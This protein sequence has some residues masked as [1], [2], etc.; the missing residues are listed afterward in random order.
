[1]NKSLEG[2]L[3]LQISKAEFHKKSSSFKIYFEF[4]LGNK[5]KK[6][7]PISSQSPNWKEKITLNYS[8][9]M[10]FFF[11]VLEKKTLRKDPVLFES[12]VDLNQLRSK[13]KMEQFITVMSKTKLKGTLTLIFILYPYV[14][15]PMNIYPKIIEENL[16]QSLGDEKIFS[17][18]L[19]ND[20]RSYQMVLNSFNNS[21]LLQTYTKKLTILSTL[22]VPGCCKFIEITEKKSETALY[23]LFIL[24]PI[25]NSKPLAEDILRRKDSSEK[26]SEFEL[27]SFLKLFIDIFSAYEKNDCFFGE[28][29]PLNLTVSPVAA[30]LFP[31][32]FYKSLE[33]PCFSDL[34]PQQEWKFPY[35]SPLLME[36]FYLTSY[37]QQLKPQSWIK[38]DVFSLGLVFLH[39]SSLKSPLGLNDCELRL[40]QRIEQEVE[41]ISYSD[42]FKNVLR[43]MLKVEESER[44]SFS[45]LSE[46]WRVKLDE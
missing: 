44:V 9:E 25:Q 42:D 37:K 38:S 29:N 46:K 41:S 12:Q 34:F 45:E 36:N 43:M 14:L 15:T 11:K 1:M 4:F 27:S 20:N 32:S 5:T 3:E 2:I 17:G 28:I 26:W 22:K 30:L 40:T 6:S 24:E 16:L 33:N 13:H 35:L 31:G 7:E 19:F 8:N 21:I 23:S 39:M 10:T 18:K